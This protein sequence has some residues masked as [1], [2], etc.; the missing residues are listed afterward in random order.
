MQLRGI[1]RAFLPL[2]QEIA[3]WNQKRYIISRKKRKRSEE[4]DE[5]N[6]SEET[7]GDEEDPYAEVDIASK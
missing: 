7:S 6:D 1:W 3:Y 4:S 5:E 2:L